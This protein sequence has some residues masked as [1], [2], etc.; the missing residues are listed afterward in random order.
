MKILAAVL[1]VVITNSAAYASY[2]TSNKT[3]AQVQAYVQAHGQ[4]LLSTG[5]ASGNYSFN[6]ADCGGTVPG[7]ACT[8]DVTFCYVGWWC[9][10]NYPAMANPSVHDQGTDSCSARR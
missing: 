8:S 7:Y 3:C 5:Q 4:T 6:Y 10:D 9:D 2:E 1:L